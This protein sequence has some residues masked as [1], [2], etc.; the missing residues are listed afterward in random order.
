[1]KMVIP[2]HMNDEHRLSY[3]N[4]N[5]FLTKIKW[6]AFFC[7]YHSLCEW[8]HIDELY[9]YELGGFL[10]ECWFFVTLTGRG[11]RKLRT[12]HAGSKL[13]VTIIIVNGFE[14][15]SERYL[16]STGAGERKAARGRDRTQQAAPCEGKEGRLLLRYA[17]HQ[18]AEVFT[19]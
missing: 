2:I 1:M 3:L 4:K 9:E 19:F 14:A 12:P 5:Y 7:P 8:K 13:N 16:L 17:D 10:L 6:L 11:W 18:L 15:K